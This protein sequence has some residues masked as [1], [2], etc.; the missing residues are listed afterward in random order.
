MLPL[1]DQLV[2]QA[3]HGDDVGEAYRLAALSGHAEGAYNI[4]A[5]PV[6]RPTASPVLGA[7]R[8]R[9]RVP[10]RAADLACK[11]RLQPVPPGW[12]DIGLSVP[13]MDTTRAREHLG[14]TPTVD[15]A[16]ALRELAGR[17]AR[18]R[19]AST[20]RRCAPTPAA[21]CASASSSPASAADLH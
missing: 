1:P 10:T 6:L 9:S 17:H 18:A 14:W 20:R 12:V 2:V 8:V 15:A 11:A 19:P 3:V 13:I 7:R 16:D 21:R 5:D 4:A